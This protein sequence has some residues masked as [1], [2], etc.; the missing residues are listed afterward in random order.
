MYAIHVVMAAAAGLLGVLALSAVKGRREQRTVTILACAALIVGHL[1]SLLPAAPEW[2]ATLV[3]FASIAGFGWITWTISAALASRRDT[4]ASPA[5]PALRVVQA[6][7]VDEPAARKAAITA[8]SAEVVSIVRDQPVRHVT[9]Q[10]ILAAGPRGAER[11]TGSTYVAAKLVDYVEPH[12]GSRQARVHRRTAAR[13]APS[14]PTRTASPEQQL[15][16]LQLR[17][18]YAQHGDRAGVV[19]RDLRA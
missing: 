7:I 10:Q 15:R 8:K 9:R 13:S 5:R 12:A 16:R 17:A 6:T 19:A 3:V 14:A 18:A 4:E 1:A 2:Y 11:T